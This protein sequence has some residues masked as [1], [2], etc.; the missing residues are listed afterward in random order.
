MGDGIELWSRRAGRSLLTGAAMT[1]LAVA[2]ERWWLPP[3]VLV[4]LGVR[5]RWWTAASRP[6]G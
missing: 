4:F 2:R 3:R 6:G 5:P 1:G